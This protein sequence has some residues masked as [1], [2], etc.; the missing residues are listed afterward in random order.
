M[1]EAYSVWPLRMWICGKA[2]FNR[3]LVFLVKFNLNLIQKVFA[4]AEAEDIVGRHLGQVP[5]FSETL[6]VD[7][8]G[9]STYWERK[10]KGEESA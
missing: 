6:F 2:D 9:V 5:T 7:V 4:S 3:K 10:E 8:D 1:N